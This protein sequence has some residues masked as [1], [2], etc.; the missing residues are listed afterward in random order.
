M[1]L[2]PS[3]PE[4]WLR[5][6][7]GRWKEDCGLIWQYREW[8]FNALLAEARGT[9]AALSSMGLRWGEPLAVISGRSHCIASM[10][11]AALV[12]G[13]PM[14]PVRPDALGVARLLARCRITQVVHGE[15]P[16]ELPTH[17]RC[18]PVPSNLP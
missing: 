10:L 6:A 2:W 17:V 16:I 7:A 12:G 9:V 14:L 8:T 5:D 15:G 3:D 1:S 4:S 13:S 11:Y 18:F